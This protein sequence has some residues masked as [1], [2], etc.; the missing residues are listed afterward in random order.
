MIFHTRETDDG[1][2]EILLDDEGID[3][4]ERGLAQLRDTDLDHMLT[5]P[6]ITVD[7]VGEF[8]MK[9]VRT[10]EDDG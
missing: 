6:S 3:Y 1:N 5:T 8:M 9:R 2:F 10:G 7:G 4:L